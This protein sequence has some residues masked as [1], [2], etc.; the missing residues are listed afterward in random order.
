MFFLP[1][2]EQI[3]RTIKTETAFSGLD[4]RPGAS[5]DSLSD[6]CGISASGFPV[7]TA[8]NPRVKQTGT[9]GDGC[10]LLSPDGHEMLE[11]P[12]G[13][14]PVV[15]RFFAADGSPAQASITLENGESILAAAC[16]LGDLVILAQ[17]SDS[18]RLVRFNSAGAQT[19]S[20]DMTAL[21]GSPPFGSIGMLTYR[22]RLMIYQNDALHIGYYGSLEDWEKYTEDSDAL[23]PLA[24]QKLL[25]PGRSFT[26]GILYKS[27]PVFF[28]K[29][30]M[31]LL[32]QEKKPFEL[33]KAADIGCINPRTAAVCNGVLYFLSEGGVMAYAGSGIPVPVSQKLPLLSDRLAQ[34][35]ACGFDG[36]YYIG[37]FSYD[38][39][40]GEWT[41]LWEPLENGAV[42]AAC[43]YGGKIYF[44]DKA[45]NSAA[46]Y[47]YDPVR[48]DQTAA[49]VPWHFTT[50]ELYETEPGKKK[51]S[52]I[53][54]RVQPEQNVSLS[55]SV[56]A[57]SGEWQTLFEGTI[58]HADA[59]EL[60][61]RIPPCE[62][63]R[64]RFEGTGKLTI[65]YIRRIYRI[66]PD[67]KIHPFL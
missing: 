61:V 30:A 33:V 53:A 23:K 14:Q 37:E 56:S 42:A 67:G 13:G 9:P 45:D 54:F 10:D 35:G 40:S 47:R 52:A 60:R 38:S 7:L 24:A 66:I 59:Q 48:F 65:P 63:Y 18:I 16:F 6:C 26:C 44:L 27:R 49:P 39:T 51:L 55:V 41:K 1:K 34:S 17:K 29:D 25:M 46:I 8:C 20:V 2:L 62:H 32:Y 36:T 28:Q 4:N 21:L 19:Q 57:D 64:L 43:S 50:Q 31:Y 3:Q 12:G 22:N 5:D 15:R 11:I 58:T